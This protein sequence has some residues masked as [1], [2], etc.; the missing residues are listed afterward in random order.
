M[1][2]SWLSSSVVVAVSGLLSFVVVA[3]SWLSS[4]VVVAVSGLLSF[5]VVAVSGLVFVVCSCGCLWVSVCCL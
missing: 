1:A 2:G 4:F 5:V 3:G